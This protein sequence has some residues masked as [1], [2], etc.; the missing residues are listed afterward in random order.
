MRILFT[1]LL[2]LFVLQSARAQWAIQNAATLPN[3]FIYQVEAVDANIVW[4]ASPYMEVIKTTDGGQTWNTYPII[5]PTFTSASVTAVSA[6]DANTAWIVVSEMGQITQSK[7]Y[8]TADGGLSW[9][10]QQT[11]YS[12]PGT[13]AFHIH[14]FDASSGV[15]LGSRNIQGQPSVTEIITTADGGNTWNVVPAANMPA[16]PSQDLLYNTLTTVGNSIWIM[17]FNRDVLKSVDKGLTWSSKPIGFTSPLGGLMESSLA[18]SD[19]ANGLAGFNGELRRT[20]DGGTTWSN[21]VT[22]GPLFPF[23]IIPV[24]GTSYYISSSRD[25]AA[26]GSS[27]SLDNGATW[28]QLENTFRHFDMEFTDANTGFSGGF[29]QMQKFRGSLLGRTENALAA[30]HFTIAPNP[31]N[32]IFTVSGPV[33]QNVAVEV[34]NAWGNK[35]FQKQSTL[36]QPLK[37]DISSQ[38]KGVYFVK[39]LHK[40]QVTNQKIILQ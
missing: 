5:D 21:V 3:S 16:V 25:M 38:P 11:A 4:A 6:I 14:F 32:G 18:F 19:A 27:I 36:L 22:T 33:L 8:K 9:Q 31:G 15:A 30:P 40:G 23:R 2:S 26:P 20:T 39:L 13:Y 10:H 12:T 37:I 24:P 35:V 17:D 34:Y 1:L 7:I 29:N 28:V